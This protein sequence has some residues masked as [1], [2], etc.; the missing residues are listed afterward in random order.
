MIIRKGFSS[1]NASRPKAIP[2]FF[3]KVLLSARFFV[4]WSRRIIAIAVRGRRNLSL[5]DW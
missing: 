4:S 5:L 2:K 3:W 1:G